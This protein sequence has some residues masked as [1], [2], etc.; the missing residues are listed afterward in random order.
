MEYTDNIGRM[1]FE[2]LTSF[3]IAIIET[4]HLRGGK[5]DSNRWPDEYIIALN[6][7]IHSI[8]EV[9]ENSGELED[10]WLL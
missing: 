7:G 6:L 10:I 3:D 4:I 5:R 1:V 2:A 9:T 8:R